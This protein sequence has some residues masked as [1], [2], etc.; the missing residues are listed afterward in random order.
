MKP[1]LYFLIMFV[2]LALIAG[3]SYYLGY[4]AGYNAIHITFHHEFAIAPPD[5][6]GI[7][8]NG[9]LK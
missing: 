9:V 3:G 7:I 1:W 5:F 2:L 8:E 6:Q 4:R